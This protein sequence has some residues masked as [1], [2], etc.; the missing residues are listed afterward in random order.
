MREFSRGKSG[1]GRHRVGAHEPPPV[2]FDR[3][4]LLE[5]LMGDESLAES[6]LQDFLEDISR[7]IDGL[8]SCLEDG[9]TAG[10]AQQA[11]TIKG[12]AANVGG[13]VLSAL[14]EAYE[15]KCKAGDLVW[16]KARLAEL[17]A[18]LQEFRKA[19]AGA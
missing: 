13:E 11:H 8:R 18:R 3:D 9:D 12:A 1:T 2:I 6:I 10:A 5:R 4:G 17:D 14:A 19:S 15:K 16:G 7:Q